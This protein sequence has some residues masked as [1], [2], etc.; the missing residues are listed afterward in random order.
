MMGSPAI[1]SE[2]VRQL[3]LGRPVAR[4]RAREEQRV[5]ERQTR[6]GSVTRGQ[7]SQDRNVKMLSVVRD[8]DIRTDKGEELRQYGREQRRIFDVRINVTMQLRC[9]QRD[10]PEWIHERM[11]PLHDLA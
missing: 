5:V 4:Q 11:K 6:H 8:Q 2:S 9:P 10:R 7:P 3:L 1:D